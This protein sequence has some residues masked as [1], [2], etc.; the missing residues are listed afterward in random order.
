MPNT[1][2]SFKQFTVE[3]K[4]CAMKVTTDACLFGAWVADQIID[5]KYILDIGGGTGLLSLMLAQKNK[6]MDITTV[7]IEANCYEQLCENIQQSNYATQ[8]HPVH[9]NIIDFHSPT[10][11]NTIISNPPFYTNQLKSDRTSVNQARHEESLSLNELFA[12]VNKLLDVNGH[13]YVLLPYYRMKETITLAQGMGLNATVC[14]VVHQTDV[15]QAFRVMFRFEKRPTSPVQTSIT[16]AEKNGHYTE[17]FSRLLR[18]Y[19]LHL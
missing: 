7:E 15:H 16:I 6:S 8:I 3:Q 17:E 18:D 5:Q 19:Y 14:T 13:F 12:S 2:F 1:Y 4:S 11:F 9:Q 10:Q